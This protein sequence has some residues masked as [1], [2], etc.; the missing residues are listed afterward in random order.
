MLK[1][2]PDTKMGRNLVMSF[3]GHEIDDPDVLE[4]CKEMSK[5]KSSSGFFGIKAFFV[6][7]FAV[8]VSPK[9]LK[10]A[11]AV[12]I[13][14]WNLLK[15]FEHFKSSKDLLEN[16][17]ANIYRLEGIKLHGPCSMGSSMKCLLLKLVLENAKS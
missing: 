1:G 12:Y 15:E 10:K 8:I 7:I 11:I 6:M 9:R 3:F 4:Y 14:S 5:E 16:L 17:F 2:Y 13:G